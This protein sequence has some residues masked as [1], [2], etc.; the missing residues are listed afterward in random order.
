MSGKPQRMLGH[1]IPALGQSTDG[2]HTIRVSLEEETPIESESVVASHSSSSNAR[3]E[4]RAG[5]LDWH[6]TKPAL[7]HFSYR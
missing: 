5:L 6:G 3:F 1:Q 4:R 2:N 7:L